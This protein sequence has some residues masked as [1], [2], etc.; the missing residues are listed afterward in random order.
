MSKTGRNSICPCGSGKKYKKCCIDKPDQ[1]SIGESVSRYLNSFWEYEEVNEM[2][3]GEIIQRL[4]SMGIMFNADTFIKEVEE[5]YSAEQLSENWFKK[6]KVVVKGRDEDFPF[7]ATWILWE[8]LAPAHILSMEQMSDL[9]EQ[10]YKYSADDD[11][12]GAC[13]IWFKVWYTAPIG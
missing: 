13:D 3:T 10:G 5:F 7:F 11:S 12:I 9:I 6:F 1:V 4:E 8:R 2:K